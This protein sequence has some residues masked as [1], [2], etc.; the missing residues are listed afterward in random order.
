[1]SKTGK[2]VVAVAVSAT[3]LGCGAAAWAAYSW[4]QHSK[5][6]VQT[7]GAAQPTV[8]VIG[9]VAGLVPGRTEPLRVVIKNSNDFP[10]QVTKIA[11]GNER[12]AGGC[13][14]WAVRVVPIASFTVAPR[15]SRET[16]IK[17]GMEKWADQKCAGQR[18]VLDLTTVMTA[19]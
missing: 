2:T 1:M 8:T 17:I 16:T 7:A 3:V 11:G 13:P 6:T 14:E 9:D 15:S 18:F 12:T 10:V 5:V 19:G 4:T